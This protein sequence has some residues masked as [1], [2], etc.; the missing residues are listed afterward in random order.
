MAEPHVVDVQCTVDDRGNL[1]AVEFDTL[2][3][4][5]VRVFAV[6]GVPQG[7]ERGGHAHKKCWQALVCV[8]GAID[9][10][11][12]GQAGRHEFRITPGSGALVIPPGNWAAQSYTQASSSLLVLASHPYSASDYMSNRK[13]YEEMVERHHNG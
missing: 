4:P 8:S 6:S 3:F 2:P 10:Y 13:V 9:V 12:V 7:T 11:V 5:P 1:I